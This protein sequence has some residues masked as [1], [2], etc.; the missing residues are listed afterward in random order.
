[1]DERY[2]FHPEHVFVCAE[3][4]F[5]RKIGLWVDLTKTSRYYSKDEVLHSL[6]GLV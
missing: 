5:G 6:V 1:M 4:N 3:E 2:K